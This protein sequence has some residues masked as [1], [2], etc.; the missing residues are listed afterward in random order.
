MTKRS[1]HQ[2]QESLAEQFYKV[3]RRGDDLG[4][5]MGGGSYGLG[6]V[7][8]SP[9]QFGGGANK[10]P[11]PPAQTPP[12]P[13]QTPPPA[14]KPRV[15]VKPGE[16]Q[17]QAMLRTRREEI[18][19]SRNDQAGAKVWRSSESK[20]KVWRRGEQPSTD[21][22]SVAAGPRVSQDKTPSEPLT[23]QDLTQ[24]LRAER[25]A[26]AKAQQEREA[27]RKF[28]SPEKELKQPSPYATGAKQAI[29][30]VGVLGG[31]TG[32]TA[33][34]GYFWDKYQAD[35]AEQ[36]RQELRKPKTSTEQP[37]NRA[38]SPEVDKSGRLFKEGVQRVI[39]PKLDEEKKYS[40]DQYL[41]WAKKYADQ[42][43]VP[44]PLVLH[45]MYKETGWLRDP[46]RMRTA[47]SPTGATGVMQIQPE[48]AEK[49]YGIKIKDLVDPEKNIE[50]GVRGLAKFFN[51]YGSPEKA[52]A[53]YN[54]GEGG[55]SKFLK[56]GDLNTIRSKETRNYVKNYKDDAIHQL[57][58]FFPKDKQK[59]AQIATDIL[60]TA[61]GAGSA[62]A[63]ESNA[64]QP[65]Y[66]TL[67]DSHGVGVAQKG[68][69]WNKLSTTSSSA[70]D[71]THLKNIE[72]IPPGSVVAISLGANDLGSKKIPD[73]VDQVNKTIAAAQAR[74]LQVVHL[75]PTSTTD[76]KLREKREALRQA[77]LTGQTQAPIVNLGQASKTDP[78][79]LHLT[80]KGYRQV[81]DSI[82]Q[83]Y[84][85]GI[86]KPIG[87][88]VQPDWSKYKFGDLGTLEKIGSGQWRSTS[89]GK[90][91]TDAPELE[92]LPAMTRPETFLDKAKRT[93]PPSLGGGGE[94]VSQ[95]FGDKKKP[96]AA[97]PSATDKQPAK[98]SAYEPGTAEYDARM[99]KLQIAAGDKFSREREARLKA[100]AEKPTDKTIEL[101]RDQA[102]L[103]KAKRELSDFERAFAAA[104]AEQGAGG[105]FTWT[106][107]RTGKTGTY[108][109]LYKGEKPPKTVSAAPAD[110]ALSKGEELVDI[111]VAQAKDRFQPTAS[112]YWSA[113]AKSE[114][115][116]A[117]K[118]FDRTQERKQDIERVTQQLADEPVATPA[119]RTPEELASDELWKDI[120]A[121]AAGKSPEEISAAAQRARQELDAAIAADR[122]G[123][124]STTS[125]LYKE[126]TELPG[127]ELKGSTEPYVPPIDVPIDSEVQTRRQAAKDAIQDEIK[128]SINTASHAELHDILRL[129]GRLK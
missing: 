127:I 31:A 5:E 84:K 59:V 47:K 121:S 117:P 50:A 39:K 27:A 23:K 87:T 123:A 13:A 70:F 112:T 24:A 30:A 101:Q 14:S 65:G 110:Q 12:P 18:A 60:G 93:L 115:Q 58:K 97:A 48:Y 8:R 104:R 95:V 109:T 80:S 90:T 44:L 62:R 96:A 4:P 98:D 2:I 42:Y 37:V 21:K 46:E 85:P 126:P 76:P 103:V 77:L 53:A 129:A 86:E 51:K 29:G 94:L 106:D 26:A 83:A 92:N 36:R 32:A 22:P 17:D 45:A 40:T 105:T 55:A 78:Q 119:P 107:P 3:S 33:L 74:G 111:P 20:P 7:T 64:E 15:Q 113:P 108:G 71:P 67:G 91:V 1:L 57:D 116:Q 11:K 66:Y 6:G 35:Q 118:D 34:G 68:T 75:L 89:T 100:A 99:E 79:E 61:V 16:T 128:E 72:K 63:G 122:P 124:D 88:I 81:G 69:V 114:I 49:G 120:R 82:A 41:A 25:T 38:D 10:T 125:S 54:A 28:L 19:K 43:N 9:S 73:I 52:L 102:G 56:T